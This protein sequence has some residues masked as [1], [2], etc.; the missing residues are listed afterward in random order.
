[1]F[2]QNSLIQTTS[3]FEDGDDEPDDG[4]DETIIIVNGDE[5]VE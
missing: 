4:R 5:L 3:R 2:D 1:V